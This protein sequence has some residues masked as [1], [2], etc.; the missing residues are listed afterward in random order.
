VQ[1]RI[2]VKKHLWFA[3]LLLAA[4]LPASAQRKDPVKWSATVEPEAAPPGSQIVLKLKATIEPGWHLYSPTTPPGGPIVTSLT[5]ADSPAV[6]ESRLYQPKPVRKLDPNFNL[7]T[8]TYDGE[9]VFLFAIKLK[10]DAPS[11]PIELTAQAHYQACSDVECLRPVRRTATAIF[12]NEPGV[13]QPAAFSLPS[14]YID[15]AAATARP[16]AAP[17]ATDPTSGGGYGWFLLGAFG[18]GLA[19][20]FTPCV[21][22]MIPITMSFFLNRPQATRGGAV[23]Q[24]ALFCAGIVVLFTGIGLATTAILGP[25]GVVQIG[26]NPWVNAFIAFVFFAFGLSL[27]GAFEITLPS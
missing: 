16:A 25:F 11:G 23:G 17:T 8:E 10:P 27:L 19:A 4:S 24:A 12:R 14:G 18:F 5:L 3:V 15:V 13:A 7:D 26:S 22:P 2:E 21:F 20:I 1:V 9:P 6:A